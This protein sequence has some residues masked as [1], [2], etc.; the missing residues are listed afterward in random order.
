MPK[1]FKNISKIIAK[2]LKNYFI[3]FWILYHLCSK[4]ISI[5]LWNISGNTSDIFEKYH[6]RKYWKYFLKKKFRIM[7]WKFG[8]FFPKMSKK[9]Y[10][11]FEKYYRN[12]WASFQI[13]SKIIAWNF[14][15][16]IGNF[17]KS[18]PKN[19][20]DFEKYFG[21]FRQVFRKISRNIF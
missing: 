2:N 16:Y 15:N 1:F 4:I 19:F 9:I 13:I 3:K 8:K 7:F 12:F 14:V 17:R 21:H 20:E 10:V 18:F 11:T 6:F 5:N